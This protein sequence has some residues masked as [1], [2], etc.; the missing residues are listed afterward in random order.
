[1]DPSKVGKRSNPLIYSSLC[2]QNCPKQG[3]PHPGIFLHIFFKWADNPFFFLFA[4]KKC[5]FLLV[6]LSEYNL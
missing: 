1:M 2:Y 4:K 5:Y 3:S 6:D